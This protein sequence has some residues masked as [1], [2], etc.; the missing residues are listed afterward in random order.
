MS[1]TEPIKDK[2]QLKALANYYL[3]KNN[4]AIIR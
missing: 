2:E 3:Q 1:A 4:F